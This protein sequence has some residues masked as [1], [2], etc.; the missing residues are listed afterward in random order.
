VRVRD[1][2]GGASAVDRMWS[3][4]KQQLA[5]AGI[6]LRLDG[7]DRYRREDRAFRL[8]SREAAALVA[9]V[10][11]LEVS[12]DPD[13][14]SGLRKLA[15]LGAPILGALMDRADAGG[16]VPRARPT[17][18]AV[19]VAMLLLA[20]LAAAGLDG[21]SVPEAVAISGA[22]DADDLEAIVKLLLDVNLPFEPPYD[23]IPVE[24]DGDRVSL[25]L[26]T[27]A[28]VA[29]SLTEAELAALRG[30]GVLGVERE[31]AVAA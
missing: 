30:A 26:R 8:S 22:R 20:T 17:A 19:S 24:L 4:D 7:A 25:Y 3:R 18:H 5:A 23:A 9:R 6:A 16:P 12:G 27:P 15:V 11:T 10:R 13:L 28:V 2:D 14:E 1:Y 31:E 29:P 21:L